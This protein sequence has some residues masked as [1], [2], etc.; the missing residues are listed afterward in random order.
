MAK[1]RKHHEG[2]NGWSEWINPA[3]VYQLACCDC[4]L[5]HT[6]EFRIVRDDGGPELDSEQVVD[7]PGLRIVFRAKRNTRATGQVRRHKRK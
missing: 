5:V 4:G 1:Y 6:M 2:Q 7:D 3:Q